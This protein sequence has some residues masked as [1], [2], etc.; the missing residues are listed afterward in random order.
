[1]LLALG[2]IPI[3]CSIVT[4][5]IYGKVYNAAIAAELAILAALSYTSGS[6]RGF[7]YLLATIPPSLALFSAGLGGGDCK[8]LMTTS[9]LI[10]TINLK[11]GAYMYVYFLALLHPAWYLREGKVKGI[12][13]A[14]LASLPAPK[15]APYTWL[16]LA[17]SSSFS[18][19]GVLAT[20]LIMLA[21][22]MAA[23]YVV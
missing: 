19:R 10:S 16:M 2:C 1:M 21:Y 9:A 7:A 22:T 5:L 11:A 20:P 18:K 8:L 4:D 13:S 17:A 14:M 23:S 6:C 3:A 12:V 15:I